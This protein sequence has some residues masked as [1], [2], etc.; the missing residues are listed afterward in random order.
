M[1]VEW[2]MLDILKIESHHFDMS[3]MIYLHEER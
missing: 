1:N 2:M 3:D